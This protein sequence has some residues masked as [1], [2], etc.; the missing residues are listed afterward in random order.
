MGY[1]GSKNKSKALE[2]YAQASAQLEQDQAPVLL[3]FG[4]GHGLADEL[5][6]QADALLPPIR[7]YSDYNHLSVRTA[8]AI[9][10]DRLI[11]E[12]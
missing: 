6:E 12:K 9:T 3:L 8:A 4:T 7:A 5:I 2:S 1:R 10:L 11:G